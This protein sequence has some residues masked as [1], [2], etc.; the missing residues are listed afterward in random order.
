[1]DSL[2]HRLENF[3]SPRVAL[4]GDFILDQYVY[5]D[6]ERINPEAPVPILRIVRSENM[7]G[8][9]GNVASAVPAL[10]ATVS[11]VG[12]VG[13]D[14]HGQELCRL[15]EASGADIRG[16]IRLGDRPTSVKTRFV[17]L[18]QH[19]HAQQML[20]V[21]DECAAALG[22]PVQDELR[23]LVRAALAQADILILEDY[24]KG[25]L[26]DANTPGL[27]ADAVQAGKRVIVDPARISDYRRYRGATLLKPNRYEAALASGVEI[28]DDASLE[29]AAR[30]LAATTDAQAI[31]ISLDREGAYLYRAEGGGKRIPHRRPRAVYDITGAG[32]ETVA[33]LA[34]ALA[35]GCDYEQA[36]ELANVAGGLEVERFGF[37]PIRKQEIIDEIHRMVGLR[38]G[39]ALDRTHI[40]DELSRRRQRGETVVFT[41]GCFDLLHVGHVKYLQQ[42]RELGHCLV[43]AI[44]SDAS[45]R[46]LKGPSRPVVGQVER[47]EMLAALECVDYVTVFDEDTPIPLL[48]L[49]RPDILAKGGSTPVIVGRELVE[50]YGGQVVTLDLVDGQSTTQIIGRILD[51]AG[52]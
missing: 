51:K 22:P 7:V 37:V 9:A 39:K 3:G 27:I 6:V 18:A 19:R 16:L 33:V 47:A 2:I 8:G 21:D 35:A 10:D 38:G 1:M 48:E 4:V 40:R 12:V 28:T 41:N 46:K 32:D 36:E 52:Q 26:T 42:A 14:A 20:R 24:N 17:G 44:N 30:R 5:G 45:V 49:L 23:A 43:V 50:S 25:V 34:V 31:V 15:L 11:C 29:E 13:Q